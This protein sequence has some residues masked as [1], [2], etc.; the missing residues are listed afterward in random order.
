MSASESEVTL[1]LY[2]WSNGD[3][4]ALR[5][6]IPLVY[7]DL[8][9][10][11][12]SYLVR[13]QPDHM[14][15]ATG[16]VNEVYLRLTDCREMKWK[17]RSHLLAV[18]CRFMRRIL[19]DFARGQRSL[20]R[21]AGALVSMDA[22]IHAVHE[23]NRDLVAIDDA[24]RVLHDIDPRKSQLVELR[25]FGGLSIEEAAEV[26]NLSPS[27]VLREWKLTRLWLWRQIQTE[28]VHEHRAVA[29]R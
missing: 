24:L 9:R 16:L 23:Q 12:R 25:F 29:A 27:S 6:L 11:A 5:K 26:L 17:G 13:E 3:E 18:A 10:L 4:Q 20:K 21:G 1:L 28:P 15:Q 7:H 19:V 22:A 14:L 2:A 8:H